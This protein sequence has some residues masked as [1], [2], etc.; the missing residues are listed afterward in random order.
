MF[1]VGNECDGPHAARV[2][3]KAG[4]FFARGEVPQ[5]HGLVLAAREYQFSVR[6]DGHAMNHVG[7]AFEPANFLGGI[8]IPQADG[9]VE[10]H[11][12]LFGGEE[13]AAAGRERPATIGS[14]SRAP[15]ERFVALEPA[16]KPAVIR[17]PKPQRVVLAGRKETAAIGGES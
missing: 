11:M 14:E 13:T 6:G 16:D 8:R 3:L 9:A 10:S 7:V 12:T 17:F 15:D 5:P 4:A 2:P 1:A